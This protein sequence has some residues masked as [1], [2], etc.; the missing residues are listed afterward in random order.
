VL[1]LETLFGT[2]IN[3][4]PEALDAAAWG[5]D[6]I[7]MRISPDDLFVYNDMF[8]PKDVGVDAVRAADEHAII[9]NET[10][11]CGTWLAPNQVE[12]VLTHI[13]WTL[14]TE[15][16]ALAQGFIAG[17][18]A[19]LWLTDNISMLLVG[20]QNASDLLERLGI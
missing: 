6:T 10:G 14:P 4:L 5:P 13:E 8:S 2:R 9:E 3:A 17:V 18:P 11:F 16:P 12:Q 7:A 19:K 15:R 20:R 1:A